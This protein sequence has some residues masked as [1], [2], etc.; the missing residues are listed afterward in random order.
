M[1]RN[2][3][4]SRRHAVTM[5]GSGLAA[6]MRLSQGLPQFLASRYI[7]DGANLG[8]LVDLNDA[9][10]L[11]T[12]PTGSNQSAVPAA[13]ADFNGRLC[14]TTTGSEAY[15]SNRSVAFW[16]RIS[17]GADVETVRVWTPLA[18]AGTRVLDAT[19]FTG[20]ATGHQF[21]W[22]PASN[23][24]ASLNRSGG[25]S[26]DSMTPQSFGATGVGTPT[27]AW[28]RFK[29]PGDTNQFEC[30]RKGSL[31]TSGAYT[32]PPTVGS[33][34][35]PLTLFSNGFPAP[36]LGAVCR[37]AY[38]GMFPALTAAQRTVVNAWIQAEF[39]IAP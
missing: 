19:S 36:S 34:T 14:V 17:S 4:R 10:H 24:T 38:F 13:H 12:R 11:I 26:Q 39:G 32:N 22:D 16:G 30:R 5:P 23:V 15:Q 31:A 25:G 27:Y 8:S 28:I 9:G 29:N 33:A 37:W 20:N 1:R 3:T 21:Y 6:V 35:A 2:I 7:A 18:G